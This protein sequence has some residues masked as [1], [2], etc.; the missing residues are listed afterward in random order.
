ML[1]AALRCDT[2]AMS[3]ILEY[4]HNTKTFLLSY[5]NGAELAVVVNL[6]YL[7]VWDDYRIE[8]E[9]RAGGNSVLRLF[10]GSGQTGNF[11]GY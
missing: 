7:A 2:V 8:R 3:E 10:Q 11:R 6:V 9:D 1:D 5:S 4:V